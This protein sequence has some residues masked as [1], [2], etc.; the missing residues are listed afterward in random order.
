MRVS[1]YTEDEKE[2]LQRKPKEPALTTGRWVAGSQVSSHA[3]RRREQTGQARHGKHVH[4]FCHEEHANFI[5]L[6]S[7]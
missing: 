4:V 7:V 1:I 2:Y 6:Y 5:E 3:I